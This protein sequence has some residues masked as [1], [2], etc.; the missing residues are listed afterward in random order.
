M[1]YLFT[2]FLLNIYSLFFKNTSNSVMVIH[3][4]VVIIVVIDVFITF[5]SFVKRR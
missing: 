1:N 5:V 2:H 3:V 4:W